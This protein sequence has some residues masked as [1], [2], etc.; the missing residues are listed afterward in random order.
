MNKNPVNLNKY[1]CHLRCSDGCGMFQ[2][3]Y[4]D[5]DGGIILSYHIPKFY[6][7]NIWDILKNKVKMIW[8]IL[9]NKEYQLYE[10]NL[11][12]KNSVRVFKEF[13]S[14]I[15]VDKLFYDE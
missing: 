7:D 4:Y 2:V 11:D 9:M 12:T 8:S 3:E 10:L 13:V 15:D 5:D 1:C 6:S 14:N